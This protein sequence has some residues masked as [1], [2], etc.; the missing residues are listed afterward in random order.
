MRYVVGVLTTKNDNDT[1]TAIALTWF[2][3]PPPFSIH[4]MTLDYMRQRLLAVV[5]TTNVTTEKAIN[6]A[7]QRTAEKLYIKKRCPNPVN[8]D[9]ALNVIIQPKDSQ[10]K[11]CFPVT[12]QKNHWLLTGAKRAITDWPEI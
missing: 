8:D 3:H 6:A 10:Y 12:V 2:S 5:R 11:F 7:L 4:G 9:P 1:I